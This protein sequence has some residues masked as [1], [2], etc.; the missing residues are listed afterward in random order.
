MGEVF[1]GE[2]RQLGRKVA[3]KFLAEALE[4]DQTAGERLQREARSAAALDHPYICK[5]YEL[6]EI[7]GR[8]GIVME[9][10]EGETLQARLRRTPLSAKEALE[11]AGEIA[12]ALEEAHAHRVVHRDL[13]PPNVMLTAQGHVKVMDFGL[14]T[15]APASSASQADADTIGPLTESGARIGTPGYMSP[16]QLLG[17]QVD[18]RSDIFGFGILLYEM[19]A[20]VHPFTRSS[21]SGTMSAILRETPAPVGQ[22]AKDAPAAARVTLDR[23]LAKE[24]QHRYQS[25]GEVRAVLRQLLQDASGMTPAPQTAP[26]AATSTVDRTPFVGRESERAEVR[27]LLERAVAGQG[28]LVLL[29]GEPGVGKTRLEEEILT[30]GGQR[31]CLAL[32]G[33]CY[34]TEGTPPFIPWVEIVEQAAALVPTAAFR[35][36]LGD[37]AP[38]VAK[39][40]P[41]LRQTFPD[42]PPPIELPPEQQRRYLF[43]NFLAFLDRGARVTPH[44]VLIDDLHWADDST[45]LLLQH[46]AQHL[47]QMPLLILGT[48]RDVDLDVAR[49]FAKTLE[50]F[51]RQRL[52]HKVALRRLPETGVAD[53]LEALSGQATPAHLVTAVYAETEGNPFFVEEVFQHLS[54]EGRLF[55]V[56]GQWRADLRVEDLDVPEGIRLVVGRR[57][58][59]LSPEARQLLT[60]A[61][62]MGRSFDL[63]LLEALGDAEGETLLTVLEEAEAA[64]LIQTVS[65]GREVRWEFSHGLI[66]QTLES[67]LSLPRRQRAHL[68]VAEAMER[69]RGDQIDRYAADV[70]QHLYQAGAVADLE[71]TV[72]F[73]ALAGDQ[74]LKA[75]A[76]D[77]ALRQF[78]DALSIQAER[79]EDQRTAADLR[80]GKAR[81]L[82]SL[83][84]WEEATEEWKEALSIYEALGDQAAMAAVGWELAYLL[85]WNARGREAIGVT[86]HVLDVLG[87]E[88]TADRCR[89]L[90]SRGFALSMAAECSAELTVA[91]SR[92]SPR[93][94]AWP[95]RSGTH[96]HAGRPSSRAHTTVS[97][98]CEIQRLQSMPCGRRSSTGQPAIC[99]TW[100]RCSATS[101]RCPS[102]Q[103][104]WTG[105]P[106][107]R[108]RQQ[109]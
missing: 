85:V 51:T 16:E 1:L 17:G 43:S 36:A 31:G 78:N 70:A 92:R 65:A 63:T 90:A 93:R 8:T 19:L 9:H 56:E 66:R 97:T 71:K 20:G 94:S 76:F 69:V 2:D 12:E 23:L 21:Q 38:E 91:D 86:Q 88:A 79:E 73:L 48:Y 83:G 42:I 82:R 102:R 6:A 108:K 22:Y 57:L 80:A 53:M 64:K 11:I 26:A 15:Q 18:E 49:P 33:R 89:L 96:V 77:E 103:V 40:L 87:P 104:D 61:A 50:A 62:V 10:V 24:P 109:C 5:I 95:R 100:P 27:R 105:W 72:R 37:A 75:G 32:T 68:R 67:G 29:G 101:S 55:D 106:R 30:E 107:P 59:R 46:V 98:A 47:A 84:R 28:S 60:T 13:K 14:A 44:I 3:I 35:E 34:E 74:A 39:L 45:L 99:G 58:E 7:G 4:A 54:E 81:A 52:A 25:F 41:E